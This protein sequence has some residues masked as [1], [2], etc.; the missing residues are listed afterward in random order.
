[1]NLAINPLKGRD[2][3]SLHLAIQ[4]QPTIF[5][6]WHSGTLAL[7]PEWQSAWMSEIKNVG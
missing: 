1:M 5:H 7:N 2:V 6:F 3:N 4:I